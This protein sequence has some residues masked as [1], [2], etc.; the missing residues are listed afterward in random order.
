MPPIRGYRIGEND[1][2]LGIRN[3]EITIRMYPLATV[4]SV[5]L[6][7]TSAAGERCVH[8]TVSAA[9]VSVPGTAL[10]P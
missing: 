7:L 1:C 8:K 5:C 6:W 3:Q 9:V 4:L 10:D 2:N